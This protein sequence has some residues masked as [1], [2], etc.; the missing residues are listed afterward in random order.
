[1]HIIIGAISAIAGLI[2][3]ITALRNSGFDPNSL[4]PFLWLRRRNWEKKLGTKP[5]H[6]LTQPLEAS[7]LLL[8]AAAQFSGDL[9]RD[10]KQEL[11][12][13]FE[14]EF[15]I[16]HSFAKE[17]YGS[18][19]YLLKDCGQ[20]KAEVRHILA[21]SKSE[22]TVE[23]KNSFRKMLDRAVVIEGQP[24]NDLSEVLAAIEKELDLTAA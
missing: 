19:V 2:W 21:P 7:A 1:M 15:G 24:S 20:L 17:L 22:F 14:D 9:S 23:Q 4:N 16:E 5:M 3:A 6:A 10:G 8:V 13:M 11:I 12:K 18:S